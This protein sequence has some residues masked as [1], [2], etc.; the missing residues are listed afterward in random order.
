VW[1]EHRQEV[2]AE[3]RS[4]SR[5]VCESTRLR[6]GS[7]SPSN[8]QA[9]SITHSTNVIDVI[10]VISLTRLVE[11]QQLAVLLDQGVLGLSQHGH[12]LLLRQLL[13]ACGVC[14]TL[15]ALGVVCAGASR[16]APANTK[17][18]THTAL[19]F[20]L[21]GAGVELAP[22]HNPRQ[23]AQHGLQTTRTRVP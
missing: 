8:T 14:V 9:P 20:V 15:V 2:C 17:A 18:H 4:A 11:R 7:T 13:L 21:C 23:P 16:L 19:L 10:N 1:G 3:G 22:A 5:A 12:Q 6:A